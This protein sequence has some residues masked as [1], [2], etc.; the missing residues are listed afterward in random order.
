MSIGNGITYLHDNSHNNALTTTP[1]TTTH[2]DTQKESFHEVYGESYSPS[3]SASRED[4]SSSDEE[5]KPQFHDLSRIILNT[6]KEPSPTQT[7]SSTD[8]EKKPQFH[9]LTRVTLNNPQEPSPREKQTDSGS[10]RRSTSCD[11]SKS[12]LTPESKKMK[13]TSRRVSD[14]ATR[15]KT[16][17]LFKKSDD[18]SGG[19]SQ[20][21]HSKDHSIHHGLS[22]LSEKLHADKLY[23]SMSGS[24]H[25]SL[26]AP[27]SQRE[28]KDH[29][30][31]KKTSAGENDK[32]LFPFKDRRRSFSNSVSR[33]LFS[34]TSSDKSISSSDE[35]SK[36]QRTLSKGRL[37]K[38]SSPRDGTT[39]STHK[40][41]N[42]SFATSNNY[43]VSSDPDKHVPSHSQIIGMSDIKKRVENQR[44]LQRYY[45]SLKRVLG[46][47]N[48]RLRADDNDNLWCDY[49]KEGQKEEDKE[50]IQTI[51][52]STLKDAALLKNTW[53]FSGKLVSL[54]IL[55]NMIETAY[56]T[57]NKLANVQRRMA[58]KENKTQSKE[59]RC[60]L[61]PK[62]AS[63][64]PNDISMF[65]LGKIKI[66][67][68][69]IPETETE[70]KTSE[71][72]VSKKPYQPLM[73]EKSRLED[74]LE[75]K[76]NDLEQLNQR[77][78]QYINN[79]KDANI[80]EKIFVMNLYKSTVENHHL[81]FEFLN[82][83]TSNRALTPEMIRKAMTKKEDLK[84]KLESPLDKNPFL[85]HIN[86]EIEFLSTSETF[87][88]D[89]AYQGPPVIEPFL[90]NLPHKKEDEINELIEKLSS[91]MQILSL[92]TFNLLNF[93]I[94]TLQE[95]FGSLKQ[96]DTYS[97]CLVNY[98]FE[99]FN[100]LPNTYQNTS[101][102]KSLSFNEY[103]FK[104]YMFFV[105]LGVA[106][107]KKHDYLSSSAINT[108]LESYAIDW[109]V[110]E[111]KNIP[112]PFQ[113]ELGYLKSTCSMRD[114]FIEMRDITSD[115]H[116][117]QI[118]NTPS[119]CEF[120]NIILSFEA[121]SR[122]DT[123][124]TNIKAN[125]IKRINDTFSMLRSNYATASK[126]H[127]MQTD[128]HN[129]VYRCNVTVE[130]VKPDK[131][132]IH[133]NHKKSS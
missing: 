124:T 115:C 14:T 9:D 27:S 39:D 61:P 65:Q 67:E 87:K 118:F 1:T 24:E 45:E 35:S 76:K 19:S 4:T 7:D 105:K 68:A 104:Y 101:Y 22:H 86:E 62:D 128:V 64:F 20:G 54:K 59:D 109:I 106:L 80:F 125:K 44:L 126:N 36:E 108:G 89:K 71:S 56:P 93:D 13:Q 66:A 53:F 103:F 72:G 88:Y 98:I 60:F 6:A 49:S 32:V 34:T 55:G 111:M 52:Y 26:S 95:S 82:A 29:S 100:N 42:V 15:S 119:L 16:I 57:K 117:D 47:P 18:S 129:V 90:S 8:D 74:A 114:N 94:F 81:F 38:K 91:D 79:N 83:W 130:P 122:L 11:I 63:Q 40:I 46:N 113:K 5:K 70:T 48:V 37:S 23:K 85:I 31:R 17:S 123:D 21:K 99:T 92:E 112:R 110:Q 41:G 30:P 121:I 75:F 127:T 50:I 43:F 133:P 132:L 3:S 2:D 51:L 131:K 69:V 77:V 25:E 96:P 73:L 84:I 78:A 97:N 33:N 120:K 12:P 58:L 107:L 102:N 10:A 116:N 28:T